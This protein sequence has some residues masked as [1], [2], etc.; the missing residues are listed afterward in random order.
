MA[1]PRTTLLTREIIGRAAVE[2]V[3]SGAD[4]Q[5][6][7]LA[8][9]L[10]VSVSSLYHHVDGRDGIIRAMRQSLVTE[11]VHAPLGDPDWQ[12]T[13]R[14]EVENTW[15]M[16]AEHPRVLQLMVTVV[17]D[18]PDVLRFYS[19]LAD[20]LTTAGLPETEI[21]TT[22]E[23]IDAFSFGAALDALSPDT[24]LDPGHTEGRLSGLLADH[25]VGP[26]RNRAVFDRGLDL[27]LAGIAARARDPRS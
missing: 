23:V 13:I 20:A 11:Y 9:K 3:D 10:G 18:E 12:R 17:I 1:R 24:I 19:V 5:V 8:K 2:L 27:L 26:V 16:Y 4:L 7:P 21:I 14:N 22:I 15:R 6:V 25:P